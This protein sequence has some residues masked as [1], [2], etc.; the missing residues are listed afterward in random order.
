MFHQDHTAL[1][2]SCGKGVKINKIG[3]RVNFMYMNIILANGE[4]YAH[5]IVISV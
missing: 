1:R 4:K 2:Q 5:S 3:R